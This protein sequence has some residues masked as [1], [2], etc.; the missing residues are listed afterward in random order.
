MIPP[1]S[2]THLP[3]RSPSWSLLSWAIKG[4]V[5]PANH[6]FFRTILFSCAVLLALSASASA[7]TTRLRLVAANTS[8][9]NFQAYEAPGIRIF[10]GLDPDIVMIQEFNYQSG[11]LRQFVDTAFG[12]EFSFFVEPGGEQIPNGII[13]RYPIIASGDWVDSNVTNRDFAWA[14]IDIPGSKDLWAVSVHFLTTSSGSRN[15]Q[16]TLLVS[17]IN[18]NV[19]A[20]DYLVIGGDLNTR[21]RTEACIITLRAVVTDLG[22]PLDRN[23]NSNTNAGRSEPYDWVLPESELH[24]L[25]AP[26][27][28]GGNSF[29]NGLVF[30]S[31]VYTPLSEV[32]PVQSGDSGVSG[33]QH[34]AIVKDFLIPNVDGPTPTAT[35]M[36][37]TT[38]PAPTGTTISPTSTTVAPTPTGVPVSGTVFINEIHYDDDGADANEGIEIAGPAGTSLT[39]WSIVLYNGSGGASYDTIA[40]TGTIPSQQAC[41]GTLWFP[42]TLLQNGD[43]DGIA[44]TNSGG[45]VVQFLSYEGAFTASGGAAG[46]LLSTDIGVAETNATPDGF[47]LQLTGTGNAYANFTWGAAPIAHTRGLPNT[48][49]TFAGGCAATPTPTPAGGIWNLY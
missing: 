19:P 23:N 25:R 20:G 32:S 31:R 6:M 39:G 21:S 4:G 30:D 48:G 9:G 14:R 46:G 49:Q 15:A 2:K 45:Q 33:M 7:Q 36:P 29:A 10:Q 38:T 11:T 47:S 34:M 44:L 42:A 22:T 41:V 40:L 35:P 5:E 27:I 8:S 24:A 12:P 18:A 13:S 16:A 1:P 3:R 43:P 17:Y 26:V 28:I 37:T